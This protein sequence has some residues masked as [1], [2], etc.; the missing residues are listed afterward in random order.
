MVI[1]CVCCVD[2][3]LFGLVVGWSLVVCLRLARVVFVLRVVSV[4]LG[5]LVW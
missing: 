2:V 5:W 4:G 1:V 3:R